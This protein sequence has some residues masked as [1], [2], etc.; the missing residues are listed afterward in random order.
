MK[1]DFE[2]AVVSAINESF[3]TPLFIKVIFVL[4]SA[5]GDKYKTFVSA[6]EYNENEQVRLTHRNCAA[7]PC[8]LINKVEED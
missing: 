8:L 7:L 5:C 3:Q 1:V 4:V 6:V 2:V